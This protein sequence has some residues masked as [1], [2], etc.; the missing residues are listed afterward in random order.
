MD[1]YSSLSTF[2]YKLYILLILLIFKNITAIKLN[3][4]NYFVDYCIVKFDTI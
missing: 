1:F 4:R 2:I 3:V